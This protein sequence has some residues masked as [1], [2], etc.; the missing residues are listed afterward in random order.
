MP[1][2]H[3]N[4]STP[5]GSDFPERGKYVLYCLHE[6]EAGECHTDTLYGNNRQQLAK[7]R[8]WSKSWCCYCQGVEDI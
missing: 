7:K 5:Q 1:Y 2:K 6:D 8:K 3:I 4:T